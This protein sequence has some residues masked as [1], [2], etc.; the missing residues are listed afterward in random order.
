MPMPMTIQCK[1]FSH[2]YWNGAWG[3]SLTSIYTPIPVQLS[4]PGLTPTLKLILTTLNVNHLS[5]TQ[6]QV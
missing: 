4:I 2:G 5:R 6:S 3:Y 1:W